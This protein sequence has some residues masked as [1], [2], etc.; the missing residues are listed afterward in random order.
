MV[1]NQ[2]E[3]VRDEEEEVRE[4]EEEVGEEE[5]VPPSKRRKMAKQEN[6]GDGVKIKNEVKKKRKKKRKGHLHATSPEAT[7]ALG[8][9]L[10]ESLSLSPSVSGTPAGYGEEPASPAAANTWEASPRMNKPLISHRVLQ[11]MTKSSSSSDS[12]KSDQ[13]ET[14]VTSASRI[15]NGVGA[16]PVNCHSVTPT[17][18]CVAPQ[19]PASLPVASNRKV[20]RQPLHHTHTHTLSFSLSLER[21]GSTQLWYTHTPSTHTLSFPPC[22]SPHTPSSYRGSDLPP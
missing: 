6:N 18:V 12:D 2:G 5:C 16:D 13:S 17:Y 21:Y 1:T 7:V 22:H 10:T 15:P 9:G 4:E 14:T 20:R 8:N 19:S 11:H 3:E